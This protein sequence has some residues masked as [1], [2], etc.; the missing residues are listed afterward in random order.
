M[1]KIQ[2]ANLRKTF[3]TTVACDNVN[4]EIEDGEFRGPIPAE[5][6]FDPQIL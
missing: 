5:L 3:G 1:V 6:L 2:I 4:L